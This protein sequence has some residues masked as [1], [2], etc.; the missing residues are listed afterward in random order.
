MSSHSSIHH[1]IAVT[2]LKTACFL[3]RYASQGH[4][5]SER[6]LGDN[7]REQEPLAEFECG[8]ASAVAKTPY[9]SESSEHSRLPLAPPCA[10]LHS[11]SWIGSVPDCDAPLS[12][13][14]AT[15]PMQ[16]F[17]DG[18]FWKLGVRPTEGKECCMLTAITHGSQNL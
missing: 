5:G 7:H 16:R 14:A 6:S 3:P 15:S 13:L 12:F 10:N 4:G 2:Q 18:Q 11:R 8:A 17:P 9:I 1:F